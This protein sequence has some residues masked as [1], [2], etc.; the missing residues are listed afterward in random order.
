MSTEMVVRDERKSGGDDLE[1]QLVG[2][3]STS[4]AF[5]KKMTPQDITWDNVNFSVKG[6]SILQDVWGSVRG[7]RIPFFTTR[8]RTN[9]TSRTN[10]TALINHHRIFQVPAGNVAAIM[11]PSGAGKS[12]LLN[13]LAGRSG[14]Y[15]RI[16]LRHTVCSDKQYPCFST[17]QHL[18]LA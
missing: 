2:K 17:L 5:R 3:F 6:K 13:V 16:D 9:T 12:S 10:V 8:C 7:L 15:G 11:G 4:S 1:K 18:P 14:T